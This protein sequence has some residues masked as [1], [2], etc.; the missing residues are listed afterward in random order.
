MDQV[1]F[2]SAKELK[3]MSIEDLTNLAAD[4]RQYL[5]EN[6]SKTGG[7]IGANIGVV[8]LTIA[9]HHVFDSPHDRLI[10]DTGHQGYTHKLL[11]GRQGLFPT[12][13]QWGGMNRFL[14]RQESEHDIIDASHAGT[15]L[16]IASGIA[17]AMQMAG[18]PHHVIAVIG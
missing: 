4:I 16:S 9:L 11:T 6:I 10:F 12:L 7:H 13:N 18:S 14:A 2:P 3:S 5:I 1:I 8:E 17:M 15:S